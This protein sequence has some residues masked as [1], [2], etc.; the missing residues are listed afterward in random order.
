M[1]LIIV[2]TPA[3]LNFVTL[4]HMSEKRRLRDYLQQDTIFGEQARRLVNTGKIEEYLPIDV[5]AT[6]PAA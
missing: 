1:R 2:A 4:E 6:L 5:Q 3:Y